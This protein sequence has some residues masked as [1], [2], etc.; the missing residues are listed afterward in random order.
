MPIGKVAVGNKTEPQAVSLWQAPPSQ[1]ETRRVRVVC[2]P[3]GLFSACEWLGENPYAEGSSS[4]GSVSRNSPFS[5]HD[6]SVL[7]TSSDSG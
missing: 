2:A 5:I 3:G 1:N 6:F 4:T 7:A